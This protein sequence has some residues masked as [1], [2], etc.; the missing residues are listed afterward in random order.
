MMPQ[1][2][3]TDPGAVGTPQAPKRPPGEAGVW[4]FILVEMSVFTALFAALLWGR[5]NN[6]DMFSRGQAILNRPLGLINTIVLIA[7]SVLVVLAIDA[8]Q[9]D[10]YRQASH[11][12]VAAMSCGAGFVVIKAMEYGLALRHGMWIHTNTFWMMFF[13]ITGAHL[14]HV[15]VGV[16]VLGLVHRR[17]ATGLPGA[18]D[19]ELFISATCYWH[20]VDLLWLVIFPLFYLVN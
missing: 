12:L 14:L 6:P 17:T 18:R 13:V 8:A 4:V 1:T 11:Y 9:G 10:R 15:L 2:L 20:M 19:R 16:T 3:N 7:G 5:G